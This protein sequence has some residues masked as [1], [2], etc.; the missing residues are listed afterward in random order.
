MTVHLL[1]LGSNTT[2]ERALPEAVARLREA[3]GEVR[4]SRVVIAP[5]VGAPGTPDFHNQAVIVVVCG[6]SPATSGWSLL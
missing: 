5:A 1:I 3:F 6:Q 2:P 4:T